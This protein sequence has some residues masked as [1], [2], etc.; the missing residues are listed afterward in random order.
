MAKAIQNRGSTSV[1]YFWLPA[2]LLP[3]TVPSGCRCTKTLFALPMVTGA[4]AGCYCG[5][6]AGSLPMLPGALYSRGAGACLQRCLWH[7]T[8]SLPARLA[9]T[10]P[11][12]GALRHPRILLVTADY[13]SFVA[14]RQ[15]RFA[16][17]KPFYTQ[18]PAQPLP[19]TMG[20]D[21][22]QLSAFARLHKAMVCP[23]SGQ[24]KCSAALAAEHCLKRPLIFV[25]MCR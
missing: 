1:C 25:K 14:P 3:K 17:K 15:T 19:Q 4:A 5:K 7:H 2:V 9:A 13:I 6:I 12:M 24:Q 22:R 18:P 23:A 8:P 16:G 21:A 11:G 20:G 10:L